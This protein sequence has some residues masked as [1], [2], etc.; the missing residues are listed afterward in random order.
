MNFRSLY[1]IALFA[2][3]AIT[4]S[5]QTPAADNRRII[6]VTGSAE[7][8]ITPNEFTF[9]ITLLERVENKK[10]I[11]IEEQ[12][13]TLKRELAAIGID[14]QKDLTIYDLTSVYVRQRRMRDTMAAKDYRLKVHDIEKVG[15]LQDLA[16][17]I[18]VSQLDLVEST[19]TDMTQ[20]RK[21]IKI[22]A[23]QAARAKAEYLMGAVNERVGKTL[24]VRESE[25]S[26]SNP[27]ALR[28]NQTNI[29]SNITTYGTTTDDVQM[30]TTL[31]ISQIRLRAEI[32]ARFEIE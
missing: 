7:R 30:S 8:L 13:E 25:D 24:L 31:N 3:L 5:A 26:V 20:L 22:Q 12:E 14:V 6:E 16:D 19:H 10:K 4:A 1:A 11:T 23:L 2:I 28:R 27:S 15:K 9:K 17:R 29:S 18:N 32:F 21:E